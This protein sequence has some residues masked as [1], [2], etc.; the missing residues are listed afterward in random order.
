MPPERGMCGR[1]GVS[2]S[3]IC[4]AIARIAGGA[5]RIPRSRWVRREGCRDPA[6]ARVR[7]TDSECS[8]GARDLRA[9]LVEIRPRRKPEPYRAEPGTAGGGALPLL[10]HCARASARARTSQGASRVR[11]MIAAPSTRKVGSHLTTRC[12]FLFRRQLMRINELPGSPGAARVDPA[13]QRGYRW[14]T[15]STRRCP[16]GCDIVVSRVSTNPKLASRDS[17]NPK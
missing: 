4:P 8:T 2:G 10:G 12:V 17:T 9:A 6:A 15:C 11:G 5:R 3:T 13:L 16:F 1:V 14:E 7:F